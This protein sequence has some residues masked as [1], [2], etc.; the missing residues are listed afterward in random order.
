MGRNKTIHRNESYIK[1]IEQADQLQL[2]TKRGPI[3]TL[4]GP[5]FAL[6]ELH[7]TGRKRRSDA[8]NRFKVPLDF[9]T[10]IGLIEDDRF[11]QWG[12]VGWID[13]PAQAPPYGCRLTI[14]PCQK[15]GLPVSVA[16][17]IAEFGQGSPGESG[18]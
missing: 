14:W 13:D 10:R 2:L 5:F 8:D 18:G 11:M 4:V 17:L 16:A 6:L 3:K 15:K 9:A 7:A 12:L 1:W